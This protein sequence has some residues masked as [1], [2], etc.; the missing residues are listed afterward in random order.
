V[1]YFLLTW[2]RAVVGMQTTV[3]NNCFLDV[4]VFAKLKIV[5]DFYLLNTFFYFVFCPILLCARD[6]NHVQDMFLVQQ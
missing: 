3:M 6:K 1:K 4:A 2:T 5:P